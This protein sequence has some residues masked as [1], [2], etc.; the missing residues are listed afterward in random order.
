MLPALS[1]LLDY[2]HPKVIQTYVRTFQVDESEA[3]ALFQEMLT[4]LWISTKHTLDRQAQPNNK[5]LQF[6]FVMHQEMRPIDD[7]WH[8][9]ILYTRDYIQFCDRY[10][11]TYIH[12][13]P[14]IAIDKIPTE[15]E[16]TTNMAKY[17]EYVYEHLGEL[18]LRRWFA[19][20]FTSTEQPHAA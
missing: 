10:F 20:H 9:F 8:N 5:Q 19:N 1:D 2:Q 11:G 15:A 4:F 12:H 17:L 13:E 16:F 6:Q 18:T 14:D 7:M 3:I